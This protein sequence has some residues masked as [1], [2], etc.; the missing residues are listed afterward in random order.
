MEPKKGKLVAPDYQHREEREIFDLLNEGLE[1]TRLWVKDVSGGCGEM[2]DIEIESERFRGLSVLK[3]QRL[4]NETIGIPKI[5][6]WHGCQ[7]KTFVP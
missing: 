5:K 7:L 1:P 4:V 6:S 3:Q 2:Y